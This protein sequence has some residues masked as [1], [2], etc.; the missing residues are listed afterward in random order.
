MRPGGPSP[1]VKS[2]GK[3]VDWVEPAPNGKLS[4]RLAGQTENTA[5]VPLYQILDER[6][7]AYWKVNSKS[8]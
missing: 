3:G 4:F 2:G 7:A 8:T 6:Y 5:L 1:E